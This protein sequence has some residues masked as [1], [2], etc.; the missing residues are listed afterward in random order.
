MQKIII[1][2]P[3]SGIIN[4]QRDQENFSF[5]ED[6]QVK[7]FIVRLYEWTS[8]TISLGISQKPF[9][10]KK[11]LPFEV[12]KR[13]TGGKAVLH[14]KE[15]TYSVVS[16]LDNDKLGGS[17]HDSYNKI[18]SLLI[19]FLQTKVKDKKIEQV[20]QGEKSSAAICYHIKG[21]KEICLDGKK[22]IGSAQKRG[23]HAFLQ[24]GSIP[25]L[26]HEFF[27]ENYLEEKLSVSAD[28]YIFLSDYLPN[29]NLQKLKAEL[30]EFL[31]GKL[32]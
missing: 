14:F 29:I 18:S 16:D 23:K 6:S 21:F 19:A 24:H 17:L 3:Q 25:C 11:D 28:N 27:L 30:Q 12:V 9:F 22:L 5:F 2:S 31:T 1:D 10:L 15:I 20:A 7:G 8:P 26:R 32:L 4:M 13:I